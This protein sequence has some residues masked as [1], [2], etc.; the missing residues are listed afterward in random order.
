MIRSLFDGEK[1]S[2]SAFDLEKDAATLALWTHDPGYLQLLDQ[3][4]ARP[5][6]PGQ[7]KKKIQSE[8]KPENQHFRFAVRTRDESRL[9]GMVALHWVEY[10]NGY[11]WLTLGIGS[12][13][14]RGR[15]FGSETLRLILNYAFNELNLHR[16]N[17]WLVEYNQTA[18]RLLESHGFK[19]EVR[20]RQAIHRFDRR[21]D[22]LMMG[23]LQSDWLALHEHPQ[24]SS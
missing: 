23:I 10:S 20:S 15:G 17:C 1:V 2:L 19:L 22:S 16:V 21:F 14:D 13:L 9:V 7:I 8:D 6:T 4:P 3:D 12:P 11:A 5:L 24:V 18:R